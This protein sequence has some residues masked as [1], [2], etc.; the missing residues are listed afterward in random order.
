MRLA[1]LIMMIMS[2][3]A[4]NVAR[5]EEPSE[6]PHVVDNTLPESGCAR[7]REPGLVDGPVAMGLFQGD[8]GAGRRACPR[9]ELAL[10]VRAGAIIDTPNFYGNLSV[11][12]ILEASMN[13]RD[14]AELFISV[15]FI[16]W[17]YVQNAS[18]TGSQA[19]LGAMSVGGSIIALDKKGAVLS[20]YA[21]V[22]LPTDVRTVGAEAGL[23]LSFR[24]SRVRTLGAH[25]VVAGDVSG[26]ISGPSSVRGGGLLILGLE[27]T[28]ARWFGLMVD[29][30]SHLGYRAVL[31]WLAPAAAVRFRIYRGLGVELSALVPLAGADRHDVALRLRLSLRL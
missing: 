30:Q 6:P 5:A 28:P 22:L 17:Q 15:P 10:G 24:G 1:V 9:S 25:A 20:P 18:L 31:D 4:N 7:W 16:N 26:G 2:V 11:D 19:R 29:L 12:A 21:R 14:R 23:A 13:L 3:A 8:L 27:W